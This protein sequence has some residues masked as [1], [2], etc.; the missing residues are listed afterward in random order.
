MADP[1][2]PPA[3]GPSTG[4]AQRLQANLSRFMLGYALLA[5]AAGLAL[6]SRRRPGTPRTRT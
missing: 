1:H 5:M 2:I 6:G 4:R 3:S